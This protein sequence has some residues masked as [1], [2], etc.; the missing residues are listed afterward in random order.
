MPDIV[1]STKTASHTHTYSM[2]VHGVCVRICL[3]CIPVTYTDVV[4]TKSKVKQQNKWT[5]LK[6]KGKKLNRYGIHNWPISLNWVDLNMAA[7]AALEM[8]TKGLI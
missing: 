1:L 8:P 5:A 4:Q 3:V 2:C 6:L 7:M